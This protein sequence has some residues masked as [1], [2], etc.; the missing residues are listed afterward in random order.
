VERRCPCGRSIAHKRHDAKYCCPAHKKAGQRGRLVSVPM[1]REEGGTG[2][3]TVDESVVEATRRELEAAGRLDTAL[4]RATLKLAAQLDA[5][6][7]TGSSSAALAR[8]FAAML[9]DATRGSE[10]EVTE[11][12][13]LRMKRLE[14]GA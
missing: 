11:L 3:G 5:G 1:D 6:H 9:A 4:G 8:Q 7:D 10:A 2:A 13:R 12:D 14:R